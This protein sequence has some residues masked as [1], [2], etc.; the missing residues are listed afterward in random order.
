GAVVLG[1]GGGGL[2]AAATALGATHL[3]RRVLDH[4]VDERED[5]EVAPEADVLARV[6]DGALLAHQDVPGGHVLAA[7]HLDAALLRSR[8]ATV[9]RRAPSSFLSPLLSSWPLTAVLDRG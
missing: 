5:R 9:A 1:G 6:D 2:D 8:V 4:A 7:D 3:E